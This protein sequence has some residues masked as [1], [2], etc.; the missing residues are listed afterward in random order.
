MILLYTG[1][2]IPDAPQLNAEKS[3]GGFVSST[4]IPNSRLS[5]LFSGISKSVI[6]NQKKEIKLIA[7]RNTTGSIINNLQIYTNNKN[8]SFLLQIAAVASGVNSNNE[9]VFE[10]VQDGESLPYQATLTSNEGITN[11]LNIGT[12]AV[13]QTIG[14]WIYRSLDITKYPEF[15]NQ[16]VQTAPLSTSDLVTI[17]QSKTIDTEEDIDLVIKWQ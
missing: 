1:S 14:I 3:L 9:L 8:K 15:I 12:L 5:N 6:L 13:G 11:A 10:Q 4:P 16:V 17:L 2:N 7:L